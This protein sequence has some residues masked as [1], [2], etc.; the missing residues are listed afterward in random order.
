MRHWQK[1][2]RRPFIAAGMKKLLQLQPEKM[3]W[4]YPLK[5]LRKHLLHKHIIRLLGG[6]PS[7][8]AQ[9]I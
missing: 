3:L 5:K 2:M 8:S 7:G 6:A 1:P 4:K 9:I